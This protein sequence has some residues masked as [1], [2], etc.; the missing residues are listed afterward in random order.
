MTR[1]DLELVGALTLALETARR[2]IRD[3]HNIN[4]G[5]NELLRESQW[6]LYDGHAPEM[7]LINDGIARG[8]RAL[9]RHNGDGGES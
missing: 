4:T 7:A 2:T 3:W 6:K 9:G 5:P 1:Q 8:H